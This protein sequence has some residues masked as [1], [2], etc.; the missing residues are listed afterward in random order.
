M[1]R[2]KDLDTNYLFAGT[3]ISTHSVWISSVSPSHIHTWQH[4]ALPETLFL[5]DRTHPLLQNRA[6][7][8]GGGGITHPQ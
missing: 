8:G 1:L 6:A 2:N 3:R 4:E 5:G 7:V